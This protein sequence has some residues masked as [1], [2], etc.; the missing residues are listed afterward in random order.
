MMTGLPVVMGMSAVMG[1]PV[2]KDACGQC[3]AGTPVSLEKRARDL[4]MGRW[5]IKICRSKGTIK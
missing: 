3:I 2:F 4:Y 1:M 5:F